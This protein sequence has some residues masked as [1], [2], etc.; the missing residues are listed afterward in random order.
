MSLAQERERLLQTESLAHFRREM[1]PAEMVTVYQS[2]DWDKSKKHSYFTYCALVPSSEVDQ[3]LSSCEWLYLL[4]DSV[5]CYRFDDENEITPLVIGRSFNS[6]REDYVEIREEFRLFHNLYQ[7]DRDNRFDNYIKLEESGN[8]QIVAIVDREP[9]RVRI[10][11]K[12]IRQFLAIKGMHL[13][14]QFD[15]LEFS[16]KS[17]EELGLS[18][19]RREVRED[20]SWWRC[21][22]DDATGL[23]SDRKT[24]SVLRGLR[25]I[26]PL[27]ESESD[28]PGFVDGPK[29]R[30]IDF[31]IGMG[32]NGDE[33]E[34]TCNP[35]T[36][37]NYFGRNPGAPHEL[38]PVSFR[39]DV[40]DKYYRQSR[41]YSV[42]VDTVRCGDLWNIY[43]DND[44]DDKICVWLVDLGKLPYE[45]QLHWRSCNL[46][47][48]DGVSES[49]YRQ[50]IRAEATSS[51]RPE[52]IFQYRYGELA[53]ECQDHL[54]WSLLL[55]L[56]EGDEYHIQNIRIPATDEQPE[57]DELVLGLTKILVDSLNEKE[58][59]KLIPSDQ[60]RDL[61]RGIA[62]LEAAL[63]ACDIQDADKHIVFLRDLQHLRSAGTAHR[64]GKKYSKIIASFT[65][66]SRDL[67]TVFAEILTRAILFLDYLIEF[68]RRKPGIQPTAAI[69]SPGRQ[70]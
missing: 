52:H 6:I 47:S 40:L 23:D 60:R 32:E 34:H 70:G 21:S 8:E 66:N 64:K 2:S 31:I 35:N 50:Q 22:L 13:A 68:A 14:I 46:A 33:M 30:Y 24:M 56:E 19:E 27:P 10:R 26:E 37:A 38:T 17:L 65:E 69:N 9:G 5:G 45:E 11:L 63:A 53:R 48:E 61:K 12:E 1:S 51:N 25:L 7:D 15:Y 43:I 3:A 54:G 4:G 58:L 42:S 28:L 49:F 36:L 62:R 59:N 55:P 20:L 44:H 67:R 29:K 57:F 16:E 39:K 18:K 41:K